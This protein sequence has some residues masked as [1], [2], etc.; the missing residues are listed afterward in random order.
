MKPVAFPIH[1]AAELFPAPSP[2][3]RQ[4][5]LADI[6]QHGL[7][8]PIWLT[9]D[10]RLLD[11]RTRLAICNELGL[12]CPTRTYKGL[13]PEAFAVSL[14]L[15]RRHLTTQERAVIAARLVTTA[16][17]DNQFKSKKGGS[18][19]P[20]SRQVTVKKAARALNVSPKSVKRAKA[21]LEGRAA[22]VTPKKQV[23]QQRVVAQGVTSQEANKGVAA[24][25]PNAGKV[26][27]LIEKND[28]N[29]MSTQLLNRYHV[30]ELASLVPWVTETEPGTFSIDQEMRGAV[31]A[32][33][34]TRPGPDGK[35]TVQRL[36][37]LQVQVEDALAKLEKGWGNSKTRGLELRRT[38]KDMAKEL[39]DIATAFHTPA[40]AVKE[41]PRKAKADK[42]AA[43]PVAEEATKKEEDSGNQKADGGS[44]A[45]DT[46]HPF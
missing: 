37:T 2:D 20:A 41:A 34:A 27:E 22:R 31:E 46:D 21:K 1:P 14:N 45:A 39:G 3:Q 32:M 18:A 24:A 8:E 40:P 11:G 7:K 9:E 17:G 4:A 28:G 35:T 42:P 36:L 30:R 15:H 26:L 38:V 12:A 33:K 19:D 23:L 29:P 25:L 10:G 44:E 43:K 13:D 5:L 6:K 16:V